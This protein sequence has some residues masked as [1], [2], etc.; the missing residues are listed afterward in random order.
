MYFFNQDLGQDLGYK[1]V[2]DLRKKPKNPR[3]C[4]QV[5]KILSKKFKKSRSYLQEVSLGWSVIFIT[6]KV[7]TI[8]SFPV[9]SKFDFHGCLDFRMILWIEFGFSPLVKIYY[10]FNLTLV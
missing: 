4:L 8:F 3:S 6:L 2:T 7:T 10:E 1:K 9:V 5:V